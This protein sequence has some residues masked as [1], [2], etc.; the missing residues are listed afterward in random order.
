VH[1]F[2]GVNNCPNWEFGY[3]NMIENI[4]IEL[5]KSKILTINCF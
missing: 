5:K 3:Q 1:G 4:L 2:I